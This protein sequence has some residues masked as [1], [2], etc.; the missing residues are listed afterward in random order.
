M[1]STVTEVTRLTI[2][3]G[4]YPDFKTMIG[5][6]AVLLLLL[7]LGQKEVARASGGPLSKTWMQTLDIAVMPLLLAFGL[8]MLTRFLDLLPK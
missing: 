5:V 8:V 1:T 2:N 3:S 7:V 4:S 6:T